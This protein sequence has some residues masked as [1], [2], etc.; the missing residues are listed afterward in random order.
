[1]RIA[2]LGNPDSIHVRRWVRFLSR[3]GHELLL[4]VDPHTR[5]RPDE[6]EV[7][8]VEW[9]LLLKVLAYRLTPK[10]HGNALWKP[11][12]Y[13]PHITDFRPDVVHG[14]EAYY[15][16]LATAGAG[17][18]PRVLS[19][20]GRDIFID[21]RAGGLGGWMVRRAVRDVDRI[22]CNDE[23][24]VPFLSETYGVAPEKIVPFSWGIDL[25]VFSKVDAGEARRLRSELAIEAE[26]RVIFSP[27]KWGRLWGSDTLAE[28]LPEVMAASP[29]TVAVLIAPREEDREGVELKGRL[30]N[31]CDARRLRWLPPDQTP[32]TMAGLYS[33]A[34]VFVSV[35]PADLL[36]QTVLE[37]MACGCFPVLT[38]LNAYGRYAVQGETAL[39]VEPSDASALAAAMIEALEH[40]GLREQAAARNRDA[41]R[42]HEDAAVNMPK[43]EEVYAGAIESYARGIGTG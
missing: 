9:T 3:R 22:T 8:Q 28:A 39:L 15:N 40:S 18:Y 27:R 30:E 12:L 20:W 35:P 1:M 4:I 5:E 10:P 24:I 6:C 21:G 2:L 41:M 11:W 17:P 25:D 14:F 26:A 13:R 33:L 32:E 29:E 7:R 37:G 16:G 31:A 23:S 19:P 36:A 43:M 38:N 42:R 34:E